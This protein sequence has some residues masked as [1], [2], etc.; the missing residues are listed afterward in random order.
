MSPLDFRR[1]YQRRLDGLIYALLI[2][3][4]QFDG[5]IEIPARHVRCAAEEGQIGDGLAW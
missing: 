4:A 2:H 5:E 1:D 3:I